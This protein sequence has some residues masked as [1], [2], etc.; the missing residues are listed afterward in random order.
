MGGFS[1]YRNCG[2]GVIGSVG[3]TRIVDMDRRFGEIRVNGGYRGYGMFR[4]I[5]YFTFGGNL[6]VKR[7]EGNSATSKHGNLGLSP[8]N[9]IRNPLKC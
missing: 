7:V 8:L 4:P 3:A 2:W 9:Y 5:S 6:K 1:F